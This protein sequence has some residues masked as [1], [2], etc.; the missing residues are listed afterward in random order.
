MATTYEPIATTTLTSAAASITF[1]SIPATYTDLRLVLVASNTINN[2]NIRFRFN[3][4]TTANYNDIVLYG[5]RSAAACSTD[6]N[7]TENIANYSL[8]MPITPIYGLYTFDVM[9]YAGSTYKTTM[10]TASED[11]LTQGEVSTIINMWESTSIITQI[12]VR[13]TGANFTIGTSAT[14]YGIKAA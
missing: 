2:Y 13:V 9:G 4:D 8:G 1:S 7:I 6:S 12:S 14:L 10:N 5:N 3:G 11:Q